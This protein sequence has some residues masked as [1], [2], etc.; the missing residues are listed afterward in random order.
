MQALDLNLA[1]RPF[2]NNTLLWAGYGG[3]L[4]LLVAFAVWNVFAWRNSVRRIGEITVEVSSIENLLQDYDQRELKAEAGVAEFDLKS[5]AIQAVKANEVI[6]WKAFSWTRL[7][8]LMEE[9]LPYDVRMTSIR[10]LF[11]GG[12]RR[13]EMAPAEPVQG[14]TVP[15][16][17]EGLAKD[18]KAVWE[19]QNS[20]LADPHFGRVYPERLQRTDRGEIVF[21][22]TFLY[23]PDFVAEEAAVVEAIEVPE[24]V[25]DEAAVETPQ[26]PEGAASPEGEAGTPP[27]DTA[28]LAAE[29][30]TEEG[31]AAA[32]PPG[33]E[34]AA[35]AADGAKEPAERPA[36]K[37]AAT[38]KPRNEQGRAYMNTRRDNN[39][40]KRDRE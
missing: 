8:N 1:S 25:G 29:A 12:R 26:P 23:R 16:A 36:S 28:A 33:E 7:F 34:L 38:H 5:L 6:D 40:R 37:G 3:A 20:L 22:I 15:V 27:A 2:R 13:G 39:T 18:F 24:E 35:P 30:T 32:E 17:A 4:V 21:N 14:R 19:L 11:Q 31:E 10:P 9:V